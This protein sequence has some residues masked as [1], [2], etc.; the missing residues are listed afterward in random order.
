MTSMISFDYSRQWDKTR[1]DCFA[2]GM[3]DL[4]GIHMTL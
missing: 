3:V 1:I 4:L 2:I